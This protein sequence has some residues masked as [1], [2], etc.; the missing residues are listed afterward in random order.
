MCATT[1]LRV[2]VIKGTGNRHNERER[3]RER[4][5][6]DKL[7]PEHFNLSLLSEPKLLAREREEQ[8][9]KDTVNDTREKN[10]WNQKE[11]FFFLQIFF[12]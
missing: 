10:Y 4:E 7:A 1:V 3:G 8:Q 9:I 2:E 11:C 6:R 12:S 5:S